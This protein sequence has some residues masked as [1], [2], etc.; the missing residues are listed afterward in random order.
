VD[1]LTSLNSEAAIGIRNISL[2]IAP[3]QKVGICGRTGGGK[4]SLVGTL[5]RLLEIDAGTITIDG[6]DLSTIPRD[7]LR[8]R[9]VTLPQE[10][11][12]L[13]TSVRAN[14]DPHN[15]SSDAAIIDVLARVNLWDGVLG[16]REGGLDHELTPTSLSRGQNQLLALARALLKIRRGAQVLLLDEP[17]SSMDAETDGVVQRVLREEGRACT[18]LAIAH[19]VG[20]ILGSDL[21]AVM[22]EGR[23]AEVGRPEELREQGGAFSSLV[24]G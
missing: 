7:L 20:T 23:V 4:S 16:D 1:Y 11:L 10:P 8:E 3:G 13:T 5:L 17:T 15:V 12:V 2:T 21:V 14:I 19:R 24:G 18:V 6:L 9:L 22:E